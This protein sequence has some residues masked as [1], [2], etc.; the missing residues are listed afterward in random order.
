MQKNY[1]REMSITHKDFFRLLPIAL[2]GL[3]YQINANEVNVSAFNGTFLIELGDERQRKIASLTLPVL[4]VSFDFRGIAAEDVDS[5]LSKFWH[6]YQ[7][8]GG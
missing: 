8:G 3:D 4:D 5:F 1:R 7:R 2:K 6:V